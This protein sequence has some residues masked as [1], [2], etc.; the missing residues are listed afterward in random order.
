[1]RRRG[2]G[3]WC[4]RAKAFARTPNTFGH[5]LVDRTQWVSE[6][7]FRT[8]LEPG[9]SFVPE[10]GSLAGQLADV[11][12]REINEWVTSGWVKD[13]KWWAI[14]RARFYG[15][16]DRSR[17]IFGLKVFPDLDIRELIEEHREKS[18]AGGN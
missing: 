1:M 11:V 3:G 7:G 17:G 13:P 4:S 5:L 15:R 14:L 2:G 12:A 18:A 8:W 10:R 16:G 6:S 9:V